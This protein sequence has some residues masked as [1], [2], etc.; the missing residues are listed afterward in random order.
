LLYGGHVG[1]RTDFAK[2]LQKFI[3]S[4]LEFVHR[5]VDAHG[6]LLSTQEA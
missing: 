6:K 1:Q 3:G 2:K 5:V 4:P